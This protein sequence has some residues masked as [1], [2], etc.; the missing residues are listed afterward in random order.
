[1]LSITTLGVCFAFLIGPEA[2]ISGSRGTSELT[3][4]AFSSEK[5]NALLADNYGFFSS[6]NTVSRGWVYSS[7]L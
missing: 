2:T 5:V 1:M 7:Q 6:V 3:C 4:P